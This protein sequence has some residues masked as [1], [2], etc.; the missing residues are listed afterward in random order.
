MEFLSEEFKFSKIRLWE[1]L[2]NTEYM[3]NTC[4]MFVQFKWV[5]WCRKVF[6]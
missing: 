6:Q 5:L 3:K 2:D 1:W 4:E